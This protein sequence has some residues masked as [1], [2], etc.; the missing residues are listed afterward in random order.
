M[1]NNVIDFPTKPVDPTDNPEFVV[2]ELLAYCADTMT[3]NPDVFSKWDTN[4][5]ARLML[6]YHK[7]WKSDSKK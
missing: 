5:V 3:Q 4:K 1:K 6:K 7:R 2:M